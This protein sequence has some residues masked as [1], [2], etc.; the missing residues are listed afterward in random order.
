MSHEEWTAADDAVEEVREVRR[1]LW[2][3]F[4]NDPVEYRDYLSALCEQIAGAGLIKVPPPRNTGE[5]P[6]AASL[7]S[8]PPSM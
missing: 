2:E 6:A 7:R 4:D 3:R 8:G 1:Q 5:K